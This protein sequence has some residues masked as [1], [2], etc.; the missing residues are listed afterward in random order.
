VDRRADGFVLL[1]HDD[2]DA[3]RGESTCSE[4]SRGAGTDDDDITIRNRCFVL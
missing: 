1:E 4:E 3:A 2:A